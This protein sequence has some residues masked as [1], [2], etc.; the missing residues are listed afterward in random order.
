M[1]HNL[2][3]VCVVSNQFCNQRILFL[4]IP[5]FRYIHLLLPISFRLY[6]PISPSLSSSLSVGLLVLDPLC[7]VVVK[8]FNLIRSRPF[9]HLPF[10]TLLEYAKQTESDIPHFINV[11]WLNR[12]VILVAEICWSAATKSWLN[13][14]GSLEKLENQTWN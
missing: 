8:V 4:F 6:L 11:W 9:H 13:T 3:L 7:Q 10:C 1:L 5:L 2:V 14:K 12:G